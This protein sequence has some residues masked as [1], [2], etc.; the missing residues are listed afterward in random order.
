M[1]AYYVV[2]WLSGLSPSR[3]LFF[4]VGLLGIENPF[5]R[6]NISNCLAPFVLFLAFDGI[7]IALS[8]LRE[9][10]QLFPPGFGVRLTSYGRSGPK[11]PGLSSIRVMS[12]AWEEKC[13]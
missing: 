2:R 12:T 4:V 5:P 7:C 1:I 11:I 6:R 9:M 10:I 8:Y 3:R 13:V